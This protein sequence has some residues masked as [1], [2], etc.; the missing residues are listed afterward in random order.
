MANNFNVLKTGAAGKARRDLHDP[1]RIHD[2][3]R[4]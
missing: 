4:F 2:S 1:D 3:N